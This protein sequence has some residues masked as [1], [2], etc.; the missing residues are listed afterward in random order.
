MVDRERPLIDAATVGA[1]AR[2]E[3][4]YSCLSGAPKCR[5][6]LEI[7]TAAA[8]VVRCEEIGSCAYKTGSYRDD[9]CE[10][11]VCSCPVRIEFYRRYGF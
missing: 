6:T 3:K 5:A 9:G 4:A 11:S 1:A 7:E 2:C 8:L 10:V